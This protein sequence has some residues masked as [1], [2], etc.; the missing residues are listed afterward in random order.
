MRRARGQMAPTAERIR[1][2]QSA[3]AQSGHYSGAPTGKWD[4]ETVA[5]L[6]SFQ[7]DKGLTANGKLTARTLQALGL[8]SETAGVSPPRKSVAANSGVNQQ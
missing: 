5:A 6:K 4:A 8:G 7:Q 2:I 3:L 1:E